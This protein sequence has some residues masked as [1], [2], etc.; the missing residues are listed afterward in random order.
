MHPGGES[1]AEPA[2]W[3]LAGWWAGSV[4]AALVHNGIWATPN[5]AFVSLI[6]SDPGNN[7]FGNALAGDYLLTDVSLTSL[8]ALLGQTAPHEVARLHLVVLVV[9]WVLVVG[10]A[11][12]RFGHSTARNLTVLL[13]AA[14]VVTVSMQWL[15]QPDPLTALCGVAMVLV[16]RRWAVVALGVLAGLTHPEQAVFMAAVAGL[17]REFL[18][19]SASTGR[20]VFPDEPLE[21]SSLHRTWVGVVVGVGVAVGGVVLGRIL[22]QVWFTV[23]DIVVSTPRTAYLDLGLGSF[24]E[25]HTQQPVALLWSLWGPLWLVF[26]AL[27]VFFTTRASR[28]SA[29]KGAQ[30]AAAVAALMMVVALIP[31]LFTLDET[32]VYAVI[33]APLLAFGALWLAVTIPERTAAWASAGL[34]VVTA[35]IPGMMSTGVSTWRSQLDPPAMVGFLRDGTIPESDQWR[36][37]P[38]GV[39]EG[40]LTQWLLSPF[41]FVIPDPPS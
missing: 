21:R 25:H 17:V 38:P 8:A 1:P 22:T 39:D 16:P 23:T 2:L 29:P 19:E 9:G 41:D 3:R 26:I 18:P 11:R 6:A 5:L 15:G 13:A 27:A 31:V 40:D 12:W 4:L 14:P 33:T 35:F 10:L 24:V 37:A 20:S 28:S 32:R 7:P 30:T 34:L 36:K